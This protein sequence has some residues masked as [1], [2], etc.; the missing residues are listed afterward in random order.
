MRFNAMKICNTNPNASDH[1][2]FQSIFLSIIN[3]FKL[4]NK[5]A[6]TVPLDT[7]QLI[8]IHLFSTA[9][10]ENVQRIC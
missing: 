9:S 2:N 1:V 6:L 10:D 8:E 5:T 3:L 4:P 7:E